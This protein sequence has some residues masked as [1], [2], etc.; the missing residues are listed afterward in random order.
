MSKHPRLTNG[1][2]ARRPINQ[3]LTA[4]PDR[5]VMFKIAIDHKLD[6]RYSFKKLGSSGL[7]QFSNFLT[8]TVGKE[9]TITK[10]DN[11]F[12]RNRGPK[13]IERVKDQEREIV[14]YGKDR[15]A[16]RVFGYYENDYFVIHR[17]DPKHQIN[18]E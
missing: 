8:E 1:L 17:I 11:L 14:H 18:R 10:V 5:S 16:F 13:A 9:L 3:F 15:K 12:L 7:K 2:E 4:D 6:R